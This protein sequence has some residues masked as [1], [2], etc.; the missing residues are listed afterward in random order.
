[1]K[2]YTRSCRYD[3]RGSRR[4]DGPVLNSEEGRWVKAKE[5]KT[6]GISPT[7]WA[8][9]PHNRELA[10]LPVTLKKAL[11]RKYWSK[12]SVVPVLLICCNGCWNPS[13][14]TILE[15]LNTDLVCDAINTAMRELFLQIV[16]WTQTNRF[17]KVVCQSVLVWKTWVRSSRCYRYIVRNSR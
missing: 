15:V 3:L 13:G 5:V 7:A 9:A 12:L 2:F 8:G 16:Y 6:F 11:L 10:S 4:N 1:M 17:L 14:K